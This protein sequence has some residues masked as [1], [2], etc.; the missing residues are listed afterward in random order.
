MLGKLKEFAPLLLIFTVALLMV[1]GF[2]VLWH[3]NPGATSN[4]GTFP[5][6]GLIVTT[7]CTNN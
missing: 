4:P 5:Q 1:L 2:L 7:V 6:C 3:I